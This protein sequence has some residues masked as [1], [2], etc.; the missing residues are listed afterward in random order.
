MTRSI[1]Q[2]GEATGNVQWRDSVIGAGRPV[3]LSGFAGG[4]TCRNGEK[5]AGLLVVIGV[6]CVA[7]GALGNAVAII[8]TGVL[9]TLMFVRTL[10][11]VFSTLMFDFTSAPAS[12]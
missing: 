10:R 4:A 1:G 6:G 12:Y 3:A 5:A 9:L 11:Q 7:S 2:G 8:M